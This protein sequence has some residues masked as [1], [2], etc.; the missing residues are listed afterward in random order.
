MFAWI[1]CIE[2]C[3][4]SRAIEENE[5]ILLH[6]LIITNITK[7]T[8]PSNK[9]QQFIQPSFADELVKV[10]KKSMINVLYKPC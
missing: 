4:E 9:L 1:H 3:I 5:R 8:S 10:M 6:Q 2:K 7:L